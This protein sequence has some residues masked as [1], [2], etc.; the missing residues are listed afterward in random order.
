MYQHLFCL[1][2]TAI[3]AN[4][5][6]ILGENYEVISEP[7]PVPED[8]AKYKDCSKYKQYLG[9]SE[10]ENMPTDLSRY[11]RYDY[12]Y[13][14]C[15]YVN[16]GIGHRPCPPAGSMYHPGSRPYGG[17]VSSNLGVFSGQGSNT[18]YNMQSSQVFSSGSSYTN[19][20]INPPPLGPLISI[21]SVGLC[22]L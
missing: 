17:H 11:Q 22:K 10:G 3:G 13:K 4:A 9:F 2:L 7:S 15:Q 14:L 1:L 12:L 6:G 21:L 16:H 8:L 5:G 20:G 18:A 19:T